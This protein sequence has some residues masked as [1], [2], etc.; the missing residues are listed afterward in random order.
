MFSPDGSRLVFASNRATA[1]GAHDTNVFVAR[2]VDAPPK[3]AT[4]SGADRVQTDI[5]WLA[6]PARGGRGIGTEGLVAAGAY[7]EQRFRAL[8]LETRRQPF[9]VPTRVTVDPSGTRLILDGRA[10][11]AE[12]Y[13][14]LASSKE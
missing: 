14:P 2:W 12:D 9:E 4:A 1:E 7:I 13:Q 8:G 3:A 5:A 10:V 6:D 11:A